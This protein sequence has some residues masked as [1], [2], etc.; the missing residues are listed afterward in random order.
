MLSQPPNEAAIYGILSESTNFIVV[1]RSPS[2]CIIG[3][4]TVK[5]MQLIVPTTSH[6]KN[7]MRLVATTYLNTYQKTDNTSETSHLPHC[8]LVFR[9]TWQARIVD[10][11]HLPIT[12][13]MSLKPVQIRCR[14]KN[15]LILSTEQLKHQPKGCK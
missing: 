4:Q 9:M 6:T 2:I 15:I 10:P 13:D 12:C 5:I 1:V 3:C 14:I 11:R 7:D 8:K